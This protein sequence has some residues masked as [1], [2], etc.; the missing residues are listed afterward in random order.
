M[1]PLMQEMQ[2]QVKGRSVTELLLPGWLDTAEREN[3]SLWCCGITYALQKRESGRE[4]ILFR[5]RLAIY[6][7]PFSFP[8]SSAALQYLILCSSAGERKNALPL[9][10]KY[11]QVGWFCALFHY[12]LQT[13]W[14]PLFLLQSP[15]SFQHHLSTMF[16]GQDI[17]YP[18]PLMQQIMQLQRT[19]LSHVQVL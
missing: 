17:S 9:K 13:A 16:L 8:C 7:C 10:A 6:N 1:W 4:N 5:D 14:V 12:V 11:D 3:R 19:V 2:T 18:T 15:A